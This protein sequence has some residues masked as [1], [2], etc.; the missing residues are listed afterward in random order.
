ML[1]DEQVGGVKGTSEDNSVKLDNV[2]VFEMDSFLT[3]LRAPYVFIATQS[4]PELTGP[5]GPD[6][7]MP[8]HLT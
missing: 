6:N 5:M 7:G 4:S 3:V 1:R 2:T 8:H